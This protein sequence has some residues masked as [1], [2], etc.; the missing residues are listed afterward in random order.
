ME[1]EDILPQVKKQVELFRKQHPE[2]VVIIRWATATGKSKLSILLSEYFDS[3][4][5]SADS[6]Q[7]FKHMDIWT[8]KVPISIRKKIP[9]HQ[10]DIIDPN[11][12]YTAGQWK[13][14]SEK[15][16]EEIIKRNKLP[17][18]VGWTWLYI[19]TIY[20]NFTMPDAEPNEALRNKLYAKEEKNPGCL[21]EE[22]K[23]IDPKEAEKIH[24][25]SIRYLIRALEIYYTTGAT[26][27]ES[28]LQQPGKWPMLMIWLRRDK[29]D[30]NNRIDKR[31]HEMLENGLI[32]EVKWLLTE[33]YSPDPQ[34]M[35]WIGYKETIWFLK[36]EYDIDT[37]E[38]IMKKNTHQLAKKQ[39]T[40]FR[41]YINEWKENPKENVVYKVWNLSD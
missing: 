41:R 40:W 2:G 12:T 32:N 14:D 28:F 15:H 37:I 21:H 7:I 9:H 11:E 13:K 36:Q 38:E 33:G 22:L 17:L 6:R 20:K 8:D 29:D 26:K 27:S 34:S 18:I 24:P 3:E 5:I 10:I 39:R 35:Q 31:I 16:I 30:S 25:K 1:I 23:K 4:I 19:D